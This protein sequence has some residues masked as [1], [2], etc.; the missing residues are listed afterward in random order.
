ML[1]PL[2]TP[3]LMVLET[4]AV[5]A[6]V[7]KMVPLTAVLV[8]MVAHQVVEEAVVVWVIPAQILLE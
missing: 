5:G 1:E 4:V 8:E 3:G 6:G 2:E 7:L